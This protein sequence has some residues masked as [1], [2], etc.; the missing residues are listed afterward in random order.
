MSVNVPFFHACNSIAAQRGMDVSFF[1]DE[2]DGWY[3]KFAFADSRGP[4]S[5]L[6]LFM[7]PKKPTKAAP[8]P[9]VFDD[10]VAT[11]VMKAV[12]AAH[13]SRQPRIAA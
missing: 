4:Y 9:P 3:A 6:V 1:E 5:A 7:V 10:E 12:T 13:K 8:R 2:F 11:A